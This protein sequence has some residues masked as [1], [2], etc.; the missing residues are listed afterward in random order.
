VTRRKRGIWSGLVG[1]TGEWSF[2][3]P[4]GWATVAYLGSLPF[5]VTSFVRHGAPLLHSVHKTLRHAAAARE[6][7]RVQQS[8]GTHMNANLEKSIQD[9]VCLLFCSSL[10]LL[11]S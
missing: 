4:V 6:A 8:P 1:A 11:S 3:A 10:S 5:I 7:S 9:P 2:E